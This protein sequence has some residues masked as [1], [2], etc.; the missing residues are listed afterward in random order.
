MHVVGLLDDQAVILAHLGRVERE[1][2]LQQ[3]QRRALDGGER[4]AQFAVHQVQELGAQPLDLCERPE[5]LNGRHH[6]GDGS[7]FVGYRG[8]VDQRPDAAPVRHREHHLLRLRPLAAARLLRKREL[9]QGNL[10][11][12]RTPD[13]QHFQDLL[14]RSVGRAQALRN[15]AHF[16][17]E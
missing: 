7:A 5:I 11:A 6:R 4:P 17:V 15:A 10:A 14:R 8:G 1:R 12:V 16:A 13:G 2:C 3:S 9:A